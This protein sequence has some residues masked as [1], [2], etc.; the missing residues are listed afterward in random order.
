LN[1]QC[2][3]NG[4]SLGQGDMGAGMTTHFGELLARLCQTRHMCPG[5]I[6]SSGEVRF[7]DTAAGFCSLAARR[8]FEQVQARSSQTPWL[9][10]GDMLSLEVTG[11]EGQ[12]V[13]G[14]INQAVN[15]T[16]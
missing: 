16:A 11:P 1:L 14:A 2:K 12:S 8:E 13:F 15:A 3:I 10:V 6:L 4:R 9:A 5:H 7:A